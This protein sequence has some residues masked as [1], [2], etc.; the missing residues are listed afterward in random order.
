MTVGTLLLAGSTLALEAGMISGFWWLTLVGLGSYL[1]YVPFGS[2]L[3]DRLIAS[4]GAVG[5]AVFAIY[6][7][8]AVGY[9]GSV[10]MMLYR[11]FAQPEISRL[12]F[13]KAF[14][15]GMAGL[16]TACLVFSCIYFL[17]P[18]RSLRGGASGGHG[19]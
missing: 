12:A 9:T 7:A 1:A 8:D 19:T 10:G 16:G 6:V 2:V 4:T 11:D 3:F 14:T 13:F 17:S 5:T 15:W 18:A